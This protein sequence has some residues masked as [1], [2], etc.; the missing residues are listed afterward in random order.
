MYPN[1]KLQIF[2]RGERQ[3]HLARQMGISDA[4]LSKII[5]GYREPT[6]AERTLLAARLE[7]DETWL[8]EK[9]EGGAT[10]ILTTVPTNGKTPAADAVAP[11]PHVP[12]VTSRNTNRE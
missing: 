7:A 2:K 5:H 8:F 12:N 4:I 1:L 11:D 9:F 6:E 10:P 3:N